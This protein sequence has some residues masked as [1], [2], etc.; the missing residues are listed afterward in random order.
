MITRS[1]GL[2]LLVL[3]AAL[4][5]APPPAVASLIGDTVTFDLHFPTFGTIAFSDSAIVGP[6]S[7]FFF[8]DSIEVDIDASSITI[9]IAF[10]GELP[11][12]FLALIFG[13]L[14]VG[15]PGGI[16]GL[17]LTT[18]IPGMDES[19][20]AFEPDAVGV[21]LSGLTIPG[22]ALIRIDLLVATPAPAALVLLVL[23]LTMAAGRAWRRARPRARPR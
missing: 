8:E 22:L 14:D 23:G 6:G 10:S 20:L 13:D 16:V 15:T 9:G 5:G 21:L 4:T 11:G 2:G 12:P 18:A 3:V 17:A 19:R 1:V 7:E